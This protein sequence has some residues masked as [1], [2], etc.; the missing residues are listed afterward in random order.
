MVDNLLLVVD[1]MINIVFVCLWEIVYLIV[2]VYVYKM[3]V[4]EGFVRREC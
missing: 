2:S 1:K 4:V 3:V